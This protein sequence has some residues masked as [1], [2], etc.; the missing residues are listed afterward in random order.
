MY[1][2]GINTQ[3]KRIVR[4][5]GYLQDYKVLIPDIK[6][7]IVILKGQIDLVPVHI[8]LQ[9]F[10]LTA[11]VTLRIAVALYNHA[12]ITCFIIYRLQGSHFLRT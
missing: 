5:V 3:E 11:V 2:I 7:N 9:S 1:R 12:V 8:S 10:A 4:Q 6:L